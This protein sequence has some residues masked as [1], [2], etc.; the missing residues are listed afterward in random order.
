VQ[1]FDDPPSGTDGITESNV[2]TYRLVI[3]ASGD[4]A[5]DSTTEV[6]IAISA[7]EGITDPLA[8]TLYTRPVEGTGS[9]TALPT[10]L[11][12][13]GTPGDPS[14]DELVATTG[15]FSEFALASDSNPLPVELTSFEGTRQD[16]TVVL[17][18]TTASETSNA[19]F[20]IQ[21][22]AEWAEPWT[23]LGFVPGHGTTVEPQR[24]AFTDDTLPFQSDS[25]R[26]RLKQVDLDGTAHYSS[27][28]HL[29]RSTP[30]QAVLHGNFPNPFRGMT[31]IRY[32][33]PTA[34]WVTLTLYDM[35]GREVYVLV[36]EWQSAGRKE[37]PLEASNL[38]SGTYV[39]RLTSSSTSRTQKITV[40]K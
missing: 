4:L 7:F 23:D 39:L 18:W 11:D 14:D 29:R 13:N 8:I 38:A 22:R 24:Y 17:T 2:S 25:L 33:V 9:F 5:F 40:V 26:Y 30:P 31:T 27:A 21:R 28:V 3:S 12:G 1:R 34:E 15:S 16:E 32:E 20:H 36:D 37:V 35:M 6:R 10:S 19:G